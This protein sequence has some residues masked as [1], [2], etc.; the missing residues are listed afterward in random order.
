MT[1]HQLDVIIQMRYVAYFT[2]RGKYKCRQRIVWKIHCKLQWKL[3]CD[4][5]GTHCWENEG[6]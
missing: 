2:P 6:E 4:L 3:K 1:T 5:A